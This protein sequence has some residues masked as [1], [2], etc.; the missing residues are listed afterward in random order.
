MPAEEM[1][2]P[3]E[4]AP[5]LFP[6]EPAD[7][8]AVLGAALATAIAHLMLAALVPWE[9]GPEAFSGRARHQ[10]IEYA[11]EVRDE[12]AA[13]RPDPE[14]QRFVEANPDAPSS[15]PDETRNFSNRD[16]QSAQPEPVRDSSPDRTPR[17]N[18][19][20]ADS[21]KIVQGNL[22]EEKLEGSLLI[23]GGEAEAGA[24]M[25]EFQSLPPP[26]APDFTRAAVPAPADAEGMGSHL[27]PSAAEDPAPSRQ[28]RE[29]VPLALNPLTVA[30]GSVP[31]EK[32]EAGALKGAPLPRP[33]LAPRLPPGP[34]KQSARGVSRAGRMAI[35]ANFSEF[36]DY[37]QRMF[38]AVSWRWNLLAEQTRRSY[39][40][41][42]SQV[43]IEF[44]LTRQGQ[45]KDLKVI[46]SS[47]GKTATLICED[48]VK[49]PAPYGKWT[50]EMAAA[51]GERQAVRIT[52]QYR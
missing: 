17:V 39:A 3:Q 50:D 48:A 52:F 34:L 38:E 15:P 44:F 25:P 24:E 42:H 46:Q 5:G 36:G 4:G 13:A 40:E 10:E 9:M 30:S 32:E 1:H 26:S 37:L 43:E 49:S 47:A 33:R 18:G 7:R 12:M 11:G 29:I 27:K 2:R 35:D 21:P 31:A 28:E 8:G 23:T 41:M 20:E 14:R 19:E 51:L 45:V 16:Q 6:E 22:M